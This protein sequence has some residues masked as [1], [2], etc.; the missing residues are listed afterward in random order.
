MEISNSSREETSGDRAYVVVPAVY[1]FKER[2]K[3]MR[4]QAQFVFALPE[5]RAGWLIHG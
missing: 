4:E 2:G 1:T 3:A 5:R